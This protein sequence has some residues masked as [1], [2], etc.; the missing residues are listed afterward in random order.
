PKPALID[1]FKLSDRQAEDIL[2]IRLRQLARLETIKIQQELSELR[3]EKATLHDLLD[4]PSSMKRQIIKEIEADA[5]QYG[6]DRRTLIEVAERAVAETK[7]IDEPVTV[8][9]SQKG[10]VRARTGH[11]HDPA[12]FTFKAGDALYGT[13]EC[14][15]VETLLVFGSNG[16]IY[17]VPVSALPGARGDGVPIT[18]L[19]ELASGTRVL[20]YFAGTPDTTLLLASTAGYGFI[21]KTGDMTARTRG[22]K[23]FI[24]LDDGDEPLKPAPLMAD[25]SAIAC[26]SEKGRLLVFGLDEIKSLSAGGR[27]VILMDLEKGEK[28][29]AAQA[30][31]Q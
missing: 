27:G 7:V 15:T 22:G 19:I 5:K 17:S 25:A 21:A 12:Q 13:F 3:S 8:V 31:S 24:T 11:G 20:H 9:I 16:R 23:S 30:I 18:T 28:L 29:L 14:R 26:L 1:A 4:N 6:D 10:W 2:E